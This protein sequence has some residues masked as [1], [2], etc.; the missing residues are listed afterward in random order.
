[1]L[2]AY[3]AVNHLYEL[4]TTSTTQEV[5]LNLEPDLEREMLQ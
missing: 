5:K 4:M 2:Q 1:M 3:D